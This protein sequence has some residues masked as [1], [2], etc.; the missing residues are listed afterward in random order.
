MIIIGEIWYS[1]RN[2]KMN[3]KTSWLVLSASSALIFCLMTSWIN[4]TLVL[5]TPSLCL[6]GGN[7]LQDLW[8]SEA[9][10]ANSRTMSFTLSKNKTWPDSIEDYS[11]ATTN[12]RTAA[13]AEWWQPIS[14]RSSPMVL[15]TWMKNCIAASSR[16]AP[17]PLPKSEI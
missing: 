10:R 11:N 3:I 1:A 5:M 7:S 6:M 14:T 12:F 17:P 9:C 2:S 13:S 4:I 15:L 16:D 8:G